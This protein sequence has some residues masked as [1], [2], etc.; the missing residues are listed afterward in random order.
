MRW[1]CQGNFG[2]GDYWATYT[3]KPK[4]HPLTIE[5]AYDDFDKFIARINYYRKKSD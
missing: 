4:Y 3:Y 2:E 1:L 5:D